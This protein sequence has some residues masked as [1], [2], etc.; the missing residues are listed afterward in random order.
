VLDGA[1]EMILLGIALS[2]GAEEA[3]VPLFSFLQ[4]AANTRVHASRID[5]GKTTDNEKMF[6]LFMIAPIIYQ[7]SAPL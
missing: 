3:A 5:A 6:F 4:P 7:T 2:A 1:A